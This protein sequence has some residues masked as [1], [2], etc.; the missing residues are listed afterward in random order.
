MNRPIT[1]NQLEI[2]PANLWLVLGGSPLSTP[3]AFETQDALVLS[4]IPASNTVTVIKNVPW[5]AG[6]VF[7][8]WKP[9][10]D[11][12]I[13]PYYCIYNN[14]VYLCTANSPN[15]RVDESG[16]YLTKT[17]P[18]NTGSTP[19]IGSDGYGWVPL[20]YIDYSKEGFITD[21]D[22][23][24]PEFETPLTGSN[25][26]SIYSTI[27][28]KGITQEGKCC[29]YYKQATTDKITGISYAAGALLHNTANSYCFEC[30]DLAEK[31]DLYYKFKGGVGCT[32]ACDSVYEIT[33][34][35]NKL[36][37]KQSTLPPNSTGLFQLNLLKDYQSHYEGVF[38]AEINLAGIC[39]QN[40]I[41]KTKDPY[42]TIIDPHANTNA[43][44]KLLTSQVGDQ[45]YEVIGISL[46]ETGIEHVY[47]SFTI[48]GESNTTLEDAITLYTY[49]KDLFEMPESIL[50][51]KAFLVNAQISVKSIK[52]QT[53]TRNFSKIALTTN[54][55]NRKDDTITEY[56]PEAADVKNLQTTFKAQ[57]LEPGG[58]ET[59]ES[60]AFVEPQS[61]NVTCTSSRQQ[62][63]YTVTNNT[64]NNYVMY[65]KTIRTGTNYVEGKNYG[66]I[67]RG[68]GYVPGFEVEASDISDTTIA[69]VRVNDIV[70]ILG[71]DCKVFSVVNP[72][73]SK[74]NEY[75]S[76]QSTD[77]DITE[78]GD[79]VTLNFNIKVTT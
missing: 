34:L 13:Y 53:Y 73:L 17:P 69:P 38:R 77:L 54:V 6:K 5:E 45:S 76:A 36:Q 37:N 19:V 35:L 3:D 26:T 61:S 70:N 79:S 15:N 60:Q 44:V 20:Y 49:P 30:Y 24:L 50:K 59:A 68:S 74:T 33:S 52:D 4:K 29:L 7:Y 75:F 43:K 72:T 66:L 23:P 39:T 41:V 8:P 12:D 1:V 9:G 64:L 56:A 11:S 71:N 62:D 67:K 55:K 47:P 28:T 18:S 63:C 65:I 48:T 2:N 16:H 57:V 27:C 14:I 22:F 25:F 42:L 21:S 10:L 32:A 78:L 46:E 31:L 40:R 51:T 58:G